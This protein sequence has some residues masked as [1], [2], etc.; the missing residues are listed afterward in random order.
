MKWII[1]AIG[2]F[3]C[4][5]AAAQQQATPSQTAIQIDNV[6]N[7]WAQQIEAQQKMIAD[8]QKEIA[9]LKAKYE[10]KNKP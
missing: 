3:L 8:L 2:L 1:I 9:E 6:V 7:L 10:P 5:A 4:G